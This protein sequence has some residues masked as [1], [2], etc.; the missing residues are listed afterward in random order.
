M[1]NFLIYFQFEFLRSVLNFQ[2]MYF[3]WKHFQILIF[4]ISS[5]RKLYVGNK[6]EKK[7]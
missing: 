5:F 1:N 7:L 3:G 4:S 2:N 6:L